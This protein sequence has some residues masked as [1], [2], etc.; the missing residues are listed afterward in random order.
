M[1]VIEISQPLWVE[2]FVDWELIY[3][4][5][6]DKMTLAISLAEQNVLKMT[7]G[8]FGA[9]IFERTSGKI[10]AAGVNQTVPLKN[11]V[12]HA[13]VCA[14]M[15]AQRIVDS[16]SLKIDGEAKYELFTS[17]EPCCMCLGAILWSG[18][19]RLVCAATK[20]DAHHTGF[21]EGPVFEASYQHLQEKGI[22]I[23]RQLNREKAVA[24]FDLYKEKGGLVYNS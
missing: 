23:V 11:S 17:C 13:E 4:T 24:V 8:P 19:G 10:L 12:L 21:D 18:V 14:I 3:E 6:E 20:D 15:L 9:A 5:D 16:H 1:P 2:E 22:E 7:G